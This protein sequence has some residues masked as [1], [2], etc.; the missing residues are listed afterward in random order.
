MND[1]IITKQK[2]KELE[3]EL[4]ELEGPKRKEVIE[5]LAYAKSLGDLSE[6]AEYHQ[7][8]EDQAKLEDRI[9][10]IESMLETAEVASG[11]KSD[12]VGVGSTV[13]VKKAGELKKKTFII[14]GDEE[15]DMS[16]GKVSSK[17]PLGSCLVGEKKGAQ[18]VCQTPKGEVGYKIIK[19]S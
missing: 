5:A 7:A 17:S 13:E 8:R 6:N 12:V 16:Q 15:A 4:K 11:R 2:K 3:V 18:V 14:V 19:V 1:Y 9:K 10:Q